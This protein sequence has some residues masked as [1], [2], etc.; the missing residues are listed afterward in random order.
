MKKAN[1]IWF[2]DFGFENPKWELLTDS[3]GN[4]V[5]NLP[6]AIEIVRSDFTGSKFWGQVGLATTPQMELDNAE[7]DNF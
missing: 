5:F 3:E 4:L 1:L 2:K 6:M 7:W